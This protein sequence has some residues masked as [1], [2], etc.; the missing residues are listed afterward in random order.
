VRNAVVVGGGYIG[1]EMAEALVRRG[2]AVAVVDQAPEPM[3][4]LDPD[5]GAR[6]RAAM[7]GMGMDVHVSTAVS[8]FATDSA[9]HVRGVDT[10]DGTLPADLVILGLGVR[11]EVEL[12]ERAGLPLGDAGGIRTDDRQRVLGHDAIWAGGDCVEVYDRI[13][14]R[15]VAIAL[16]THANRHGRVIGRNLGGWEVTF[17]G[18]VGTAVSKVCNLE[19]AR[20]GLGEAG[21]AEAG[22]DAVAVTIESST[23]AGYF[24]GAAPIWVKMLAERGSGRLLGAQIV[25]AG[26]GSAKRIDVVA[27]ALWNDMT[28]AGLAD[29]DLSYA[30]PFSPV[31]DPVAVA[32]GQVVLALQG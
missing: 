27:T 11:P 29:V 8:G 4:T 21:A 23:R 1:I 24:P 2:V 16:G 20:T 25:G 12:A 15:H 7:E 3:G 17:P 6:V 10:S 18:V 14:R 26:E 22:Y 13:A 31:W 30:P 5:M 19:I 32:A 9:G 28:V